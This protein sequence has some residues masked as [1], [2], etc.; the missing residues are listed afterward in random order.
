MVGIRRLADPSDPSSLSN[1]LRA[2]RFEFFESLIGDLPRPLSILDIGGTGRFWENRGW[3][4]RDDIQITTAN[5]TPE[6]RKHPNIHP[7]VG[8]ATNLH[9]IADQS[10][11]IAF[12]NSVIEHLFTAEAQASMAREVVRVARAYWVQ[13]PNFWFPLEPH[14]QMVGWQWMPESVRVALIRRRRCGWRGPCPGLE[15]A[16]ATVREVQLMTREDLA[17]IFPREAT[18]RPE[19]FFGLVKSWIVH[20]GF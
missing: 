1:R 13:T 6:P 14:F 10:F 18:L 19:R 15:Q 8:D 20:G 2:R 9:Q 17:R 11:D 3:A 5:L 4:G 7:I 16:R 12:S